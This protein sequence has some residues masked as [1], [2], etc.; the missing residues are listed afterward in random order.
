MFNR[1]ESAFD[2][3]VKPVNYQKIKEAKYSAS[4]N[5]IYEKLTKMNTLKKRNTNIKNTPLL[6]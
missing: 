4:Q 5:F 3:I 6:Q 2:R 1:K